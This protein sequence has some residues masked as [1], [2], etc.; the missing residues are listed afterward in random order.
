MNNCSR[1]NV[2]QS[3]RQR[4]AKG[5]RRNDGGIMQCEYSFCRSATPTENR[6]DHR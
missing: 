3:S 4:K 1:S 6:V 5:K 2:R